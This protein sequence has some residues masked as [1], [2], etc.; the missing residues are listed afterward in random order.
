MGVTRYK[1][2]KCILVVDDS[3]DNL[4]L[5]QLILENQG[6]RVKTADS[7]EIALDRVKSYQPDLIFLD[8]MMPKMDGYE[9]VQQLREDDNLPLIPIYFVTADK[10]TD[11]DRAIAAGA[12]GIIYKPI[13]ID[14]LL[15][16][17]ARTLTASK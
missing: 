9:V 13:E 6:Y 12:N 10:C 4:Y 16:Q 11:Y 3:T 5:M 14:E 1:Q 2:E 15:S 8:V 7:G 17:V